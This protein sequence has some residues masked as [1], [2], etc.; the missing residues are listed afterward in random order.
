MHCNFLFLLIPKMRFR[1]KFKSKDISI[2]ILFAPNSN[3]TLGVDECP[4]FVIWGEIKVV[5]PESIPST[6]LPFC[7]DPLWVIFQV[8]FL[9]ESWI[10]R[11][12]RENFKK[13]DRSEIRVWLTDHPEKVSS[14][15][16]ASAY[17][18]NRRVTEQARWMKMGKTDYLVL[19]GKSPEKPEIF[20]YHG[21]LD[22][23]LIGMGRASQR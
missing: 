17:L 21:R 10:T 19:L 22:P 23:Y 7:L 14:G 1:K 18:V 16:I 3:L 20:V 11:K 12:C 15:K 4:W 13:L 5:L 2:A 8:S 9:C 6:S